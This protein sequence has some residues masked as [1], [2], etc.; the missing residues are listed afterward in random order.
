MPRNSMILAAAALAAALA[1][2]PAAAQNSG[3]YI[4]GGVG[5]AK[6]DFATGDFASLATGSYSADDSD[7]G[8]RFFGG[9]LDDNDKLPNPGNPVGIIGAGYHTD[10]GFAVTGKLSGSTL[11]LTTAASNLGLASGGPTFSVT[12]FSMAGPLESEELTAAYTMRTVDASP[13][14]DR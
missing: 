13:P 1:A 3:W 7:T 9:R 11:T 8:L 2:A 4:G 10:P 14:F 12:A 6:A 5:E